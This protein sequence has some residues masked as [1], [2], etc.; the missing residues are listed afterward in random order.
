MN[1]T[2]FWLTPAF[3]DPDKW[4]GGRFCRSA[5]GIFI[6]G[7]EIIAICLGIQ[8]EKITSPF[9][10][11]FFDAGDFHSHF[12]RRNNSLHRKCPELIPITD[13]VRYFLKRRASVRFDGAHRRPLA[14]CLRQIRRGGKTTGTVV[15]GCW[16]TSA[17]YQICRNPGATEILAKSLRAKWFFTNRW[18]GI[19]N[20]FASILHDPA[21]PDLK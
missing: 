12:L 20:G 9:Q 18:T 3:F 1:G 6:A 2:E 11:T 15:P 14:F 4:G 21:V 10:H 7:T 19:S 13:E 16:E 5:A 8:R 17:A